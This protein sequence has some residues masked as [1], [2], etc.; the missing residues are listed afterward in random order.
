[1]SYAF[2]TAWHQIRWARA[3]YPVDDVFHYEPFFL[4]AVPVEIVVFATIG[5]ADA[6][7]SPAAPF[8]VWGVP[9]R[10]C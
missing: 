2:A 1:M 5:Y 7:G 8:E 4:Y 9:K 6:A 3:G 10:S